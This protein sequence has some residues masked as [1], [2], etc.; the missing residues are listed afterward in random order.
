MPLS[1]ML[2]DSTG[3]AQ[4][5]IIAT[6]PGP[7]LVCDWEG[8]AHK[9]G[10]PITYWS[11]DEII[12]GQFPAG[13][14]PDSLVVFVPADYTQFE[15]LCKSLHAPSS[16]FVSFWIISAS[17]LTQIGEIEIARTK[18]DTRQGFGDLLNLL[19]SVLTG[20]KQ[21]TAQPGYKLEVF[22]VT[23]WQRDDK[24]APAMQG[25][26]AAWFNNML[27]IVGYCTVEIVENR[28]ATRMRIYPAPLGQDPKARGTK[29]MYIKYKESILNPNFTELNK[30][31]S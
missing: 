29:A 16:P 31:L 30:E 6:S 26:I 8:N 10:R 11:V 20:I 24:V 25:G 5:D 17:I 21:L 19:R 13:L 9:I 28:L 7:I 27:D 22:G 18:K 15:L 4:Y 12:A 2:V 14:K 3:S 1:A 23:A